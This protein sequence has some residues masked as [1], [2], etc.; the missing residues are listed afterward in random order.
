MSDLIIAVS[1]NQAVWLGILVVAWYA[2]KIYSD[3]K[4][5]SEDPPLNPVTLFREMVTQGISQTQ[6]M[7]TQL[8]SMKEADKPTPP[9]PPPQ[10]K[11]MTKLDEIKDMLQAL[12]GE[13]E[14]IKVDV[15]HL[16]D[17]VFPPEAAA[18]I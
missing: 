17:K 12:I 2:V 11:V 6:S 15:K 9:G 13:V 8:L 10:P 5:M 3:G 7:V 4:K 1:F 18:V 16:Q 14:M